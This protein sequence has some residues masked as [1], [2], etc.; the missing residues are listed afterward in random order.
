[1]VGETV[2]EKGADG[3]DGFLPKPKTKGGAR[4]GQQLPGREEVDGRDRGHADSGNAGVVEI[5]AL[6]ERDVALPL[7][8]GG[9]G[10]MGKSSSGLRL[11]DPKRLSILTPTI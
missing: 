7:P 9:R 2:S 11:R 10:G 6:I 1:V 5:V 8:S 4:P 3:R